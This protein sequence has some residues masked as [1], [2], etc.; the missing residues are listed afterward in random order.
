M[1]D[2]MRHTLKAIRLLAATAAVV[3]AVGCAASP[4]EPVEGPVFP[5]V[6]DFGDVTVQRAMPQP[7]DSSAGGPAAPSGAE[8]P[9]EPQ[10]R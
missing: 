9:A 5:G 7:A 4:V 1:E 8:E 2:A 3:L 10:P 6:T